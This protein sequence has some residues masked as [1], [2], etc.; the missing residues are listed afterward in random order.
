[1][2]I[3]AFI[4]MVKQPKVCIKKCVHHLHILIKCINCDMNLIAIYECDDK[5]I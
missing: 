1:M 3:Q 5:Y 2:P 4:L